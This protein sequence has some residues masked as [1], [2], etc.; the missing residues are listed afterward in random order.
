MN[1]HCL[2]AHRILPSSGLLRSVSWL[3]TDVSGQPIGFIVK[4]PVSKFHLVHLTLEDVSKSL[5]GHLTL[6][7]MSKSLLEHL[8][9]EDMSTSLLRH[10]TL[11]DGADRLS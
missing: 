11:E 7:D 5:L 9:L 1:K 3:S 8:T 6:E 2:H 4:C 10:L